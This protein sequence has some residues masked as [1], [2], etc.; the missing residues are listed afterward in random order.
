MKLDKLLGQASDLVEVQPP[1]CERSIRLRWPTFREW[2]ELAV[3]HRQ[4]KGED[5]SADL[6]AKTVAVCIANDRGER[7][8]KDD[9][10]AE[11]M[12]ANP[13]L[14]LWL[15]KTCWDTV[16]KEDDQVVRDEEKK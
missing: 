2:H 1:M 16:L 3:G 12:D 7:L 13:R 14:V 6:I 4:L 5:P 8:Y 11:F 15:Y 10:L 9:E